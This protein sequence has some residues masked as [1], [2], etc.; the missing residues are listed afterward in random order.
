MELFITTAA[1]SE[2]SVDFQ[3]TTRHYIPEDGT[4][5]N[6]RPENLK[7]YENDIVLPMIL[8]LYVSVVFPVY[9][10]PVLKLDFARKL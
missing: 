8:W 5:H 3:R 1:I 2:T 10:E 6:H 9:A 7:S 4:L